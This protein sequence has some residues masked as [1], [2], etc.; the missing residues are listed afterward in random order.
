[1]LVFIVEALD[2]VNDGTHNTDNRTI[3]TRFAD[4]VKLILRN[5]WTARE[6]SHAE[7]DRLRITQET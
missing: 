5:L 3:T 4:D 7:I 1:M 6:Y 2:G